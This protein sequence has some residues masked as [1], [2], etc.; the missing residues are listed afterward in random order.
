[1]SEQ[2]LC[3]E[4][5]FTTSLQQ[6]VLVCG[7][8]MQLSFFPLSNQ[9]AWSIDCQKKNQYG[10]LYAIMIYACWFGKKTYYTPTNMTKVNWY[11]WYDHIRIAVYH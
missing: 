6:L 11:V 2:S 5:T 10:P 1:M 8:Y 4:R 7:S 3:A 9:Y